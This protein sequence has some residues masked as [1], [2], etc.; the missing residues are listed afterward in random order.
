MNR[1]LLPILALAGLASPGVAFAQAAGLAGGGSC[2][3]PTIQAAVNAAAANTGATTI[4]IAA[5]TH[6]ENVVIDASTA[7]WTTLTLD[8]GDAAC[9]G[10]G[11][12]P[13]EV[14]GDTDA[15]G[16]PDGHVLDIFGMTATEILGPPARR[17][18]VNNLILRDGGP[19]RLAAG[20]V[21]AE[22]AG[23]DLA[24]CVVRDSSAGAAG[25]GGGLYATDGAD[26]RRRW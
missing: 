7:L 23:V 6:R 25:L 5:G 8:M 10:L 11:S 3:F 15:D 1:P 14:S 2:S 18:V 20:A 21:V 13:P 4:F 16:T 17:V 22:R 12:T 19:G 26:V 9:D 24:D